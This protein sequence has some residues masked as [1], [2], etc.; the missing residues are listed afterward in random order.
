MLLLGFRIWLN[1]TDSNELD[2][3]SA[4]LLGAQRIVHGNPLYG[5]FPSEIAHPDTYGPVTYEAYIPFEQ[6][7]NWHE[8]S[9]DLTAARAAAIVFDLL[10]VA[11]LFLLGRRVRG[12][13]LGIALAYAWV[14]YPFTLY[15][16]EANTNDALVVVL[17]L[18]AVLAATYRSRVAQSTRGAL[19]A[20]AGLTKFAPLALAPVLATH[21]L[22]ELPRER[23]APALAL[24]VA[25]FLGAAAIVSIPALTHSSLHT[26]YE[27]AIVYT[28][29]RTIALLG[30]GAYGGLGG[31]RLTVRIAAVVLALALAVVPRR[32]RHRRSGRGLR[33]G[34]H[35]DPAGGRPLVLPLHPLV[36][37]AGDAGTARSLRR[38]GRT[39]SSRCAGTGS[40]RARR[41]SFDGVAS[42]DW[43]EPNGWSSGWTTVHSSH[44]GRKMRKLAT[45]L[46]VALVAVA[47]AAGLAGGAF[48]AGGS[49]G[50]GSGNRSASAGQTTSPPATSTP[51]AVRTVS[52]PASPAAHRSRSPAGKP[53]AVRTVSTPRSAKAGGP[54]DRL[55]SRCPRPGGGADRGPR[56]QP[57]GCGGTVGGHDDPPGRHAGHHCSEQ[58]RRTRHR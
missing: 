30:M 24:F 25:G 32:A 9:N 29:N 56:A 41:R 57:G 13:S 22:R 34:D 35:R 26:I 17:V 55:D 14:S 1:I 4:S 16:M 20:L 51:P 27:R 36:P 54:T 2:V 47:F 49:S 12:P 7:F 53:A 33:R 23:R 48:F 40:S 10:A 58:S 5:P 19:T 46:V 43:M 44:G 42:W 38:A 28:A 18:A 39:A 52:V 8:R 15:V 45:W 31:L 6:A 21:G 37:A 3:G 11:L 50:G